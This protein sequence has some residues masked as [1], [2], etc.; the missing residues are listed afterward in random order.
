L[1]LIVPT[2]GIAAAMYAGLDPA[3]SLILGL[4]VF[5][6]VFATNSAMHSYLIIHY[7]DNDKVALNV[8]FYYMAN[9]VG[10]LSGTVCSGAVFQWAG[11]GSNGLAACLL[12]SI[13]FAATSALLCIPLHSAE[14]RRGVRSE[15]AR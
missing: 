10:R 5:G 15:V 3:M 12:T 11:M 14:Q 7:A 9:A 1:L 13:G 2:G 4:I 8:G 6:V